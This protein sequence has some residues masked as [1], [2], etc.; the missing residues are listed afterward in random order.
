MYSEESVNLL[1]MV[2]KNGQIIL[3]KYSMQYVCVNWG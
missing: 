1:K 3:A 2:K